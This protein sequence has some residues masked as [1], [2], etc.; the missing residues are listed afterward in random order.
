M[1][2]GDECQPALGAYVPACCDPAAACIKND[3]TYKWTC[4]DFPPAIGARMVGG[5]RR[6]RAAAPCL[7]APLTCP[8][9]SSP[10]LR[11]CEVCD[12]ELIDPCCEDL[13]ECR[14]PDGTPPGTPPVCDGW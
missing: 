14:V 5:V 3:K 1:L 2:T 11:S 8:P 6:G 10:P 7:R 4:V 9:T 13:A 12:P